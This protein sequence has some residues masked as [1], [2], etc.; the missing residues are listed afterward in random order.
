MSKTIIGFMGMAGVGKTTA[1]RALQAAAKT[2]LPIVYSFAGPLKEA[3]KRL[4][5]FSD[6]QVYGDLDAKSLIDPRWGFSPRQALQIIGTDCV[7]K[8]LCEDF[9]ARR[10][11]LSVEASLDHVIIIDDVRFEDEAAFIKE[12]GG[13]VVMIK[14][15]G[16][17]TLPWHASEN[18]PEHMSNILI[19]NNQSKEDFEAAV[20]HA[21][22]VS[23]PDL[24]RRGGL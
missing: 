19:T 3:V 14:R 5:L 7:R 8:M 18:P 23:Y 20:V 21:L 12:K 6:E 2:S 4:C 11:R 22:S 13:I 1:A 10:M 15:P 24:F 16:G 17:P 9:W